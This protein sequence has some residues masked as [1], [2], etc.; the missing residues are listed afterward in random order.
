M[1][2]LYVLLPIFGCFTV[3]GHA[4]YAV[5]FPELF[6]TRLRST[7]SGFCFNGG[8][9]AAASILL[10]RGWLQSDL[11]MSLEDT[12]SLLSVLFLVGAA[13]LYFLPETKGMELPE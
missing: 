2:T 6:P 13:I 11:G 4:G 5:Y 1:G 10:V 3:G 9:L 12:A 7:G 8:R